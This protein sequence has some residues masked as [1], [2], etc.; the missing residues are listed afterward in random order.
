[1]SQHFL[2]SSRAKNL[3]LASVFRMTDAEAETAF[4]KVRWPET[5]G[6]PVCPSC[7][8]VDAYD[9]RRPSGAPRFRCRACAK[10]FSVTSGTL[11]ASHKLPLRSYLAA[12]AI[13]CNEVKGKSMLAMSRDLGLSY[14]AAFVLCHKLREAVA[15]EMKGRTL[16]GDGKVAEVDGAYFGGYVKPANLRENRVDRRLAE[17]RSGK[18]KVVVIIRERGGNS[19]PAV[20][21]SEAAATRFIRSH[22][23]KGTVVN[24]DEASS[25][26]GLNATFE[27][28]RINH[29]EAYS[30]D[31]ACT[32]WAEEFFSRLRRAEIGHHHH[33]SGVYLLRYAQEA[34]WREDNRRVANGEQVERVAGLAMGSKPSVDF[35]GYWQRRAA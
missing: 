19:L 34:A 24:A 4:R 30:L 29:S 10:D 6:E 3:S 18:R 8:G 20:F 32:N 23:A 28:K 35:S 14:K 27:M 2:L 17:N 12:I 13:F 31:G 22:V 33:I 7:G 25:W 16:G 15:S 1:M 5:S 26:D 21:R 9:C 11:F